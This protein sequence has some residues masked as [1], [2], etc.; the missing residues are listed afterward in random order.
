ME[1]LAARD[2]MALVIL[3]HYAIILHRQRHRWWL[4]DTGVK[5][6][7]EVK[8]CLS[9]DSAALFEWPKLL[10]ADNDEMKLTDA[11]IYYSRS[12]SFQ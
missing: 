9:G 10:L 7:K 12:T 6:V 8:N 1:L 3:A 2:Q 4:N 11:Q 5:V